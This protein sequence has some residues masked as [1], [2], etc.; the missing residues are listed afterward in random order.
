MLAGL[1]FHLSPFVHVGVC[2]LLPILHANLHPFCSRP[3]LVYGSRTKPLQ[4]PLDS[5]INKWKALAASQVEIWDSQ[6][7]PVFEVAKPI[8]ERYSWSYNEAMAEQLA[9][10]L[11]SM[12]V[13]AMTQETND[14]RRFDIM[15]VGL[16]CI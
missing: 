2:L 8:L 16:R 6:V 11:E 9:L 1:G 3:S 14:A 13:V 12:D 10:A 5:S 15:Y 7:R 4:R